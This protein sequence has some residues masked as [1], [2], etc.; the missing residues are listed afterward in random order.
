MPAPD[1]RTIGELLADSDALSRET[2]LDVS[3]SQ[4]PAMVR[5][6]GQVVQSAARLWAALPPISVAAPSGPDLMASLRVVG[7]GIARSTSAGG[8]PGLGAMDQRLLELARNLSRAAD[9]VERF[10]QDVQPTSAESRADIAAARARVMHTLNV[11][12]HGTAVAIGKYANDLRDRLHL[13]T[14]RRRHVGLRPTVREIEAAEAVLSR[15]GVFEQVAAGYVAA[16]PV[17]ASVLGEVRPTPPTTRL[18]SALSSWDIQVHRTLAARADAADLVRIG[19]VQALIA[20]AAAI[21][22][23]VTREGP[24]STPKWS[25]DSRSPWMLPRWR[26]AEWRND[27]VSNR[28]RQLP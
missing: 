20:S 15:F 28:P 24:R 9:L 25:N 12:A 4:G 11:A 18:Q 5:T 10:G 14:Q 17:T 19:R 3:A 21:V 23:E 13:D 26:G 22:T 6:W 7:D 16:H 1:R 27:G 2:L 8:W